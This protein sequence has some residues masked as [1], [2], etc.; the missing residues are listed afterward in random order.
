MSSSSSSKWLVNFT[1]MI[2]GKHCTSRSVTFL[3]ISVAKNRRLSCLTY[4][5]SWIVSMMLA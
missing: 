5:R 1:S 2:F 4:P 3:P